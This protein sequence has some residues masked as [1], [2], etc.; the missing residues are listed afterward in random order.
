MSQDLSFFCLYMCSWRVIKFVLQ[1]QNQ[2]ALGSA[3]RG[4]QTS[5][6]MAGENPANYFTAYSA[7]HVCH[8]AM[9]LRD[10]YSLSLGHFRFN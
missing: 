7:K 5:Q 9:W 8:S 6:N 3:F 4:P 2:D 10:L 1:C